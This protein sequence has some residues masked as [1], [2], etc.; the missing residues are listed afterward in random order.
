MSTQLTPNFSLEEL[1]LSSTAQRL[2]IDNTP[3]PDIVAALTVAANGMEQVRALLGNLPIH[4]DSGYRCQALN[5]AV[6]GA[7]DSAHMEGYAVDFICPAFGAPL[8]IA[9][10]VSAAG[11]AFDQLI[12]EGTWVHISFDPRLRGLLLSAHFGPGGT[13]YSNGIAS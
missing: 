5:K 1:T 9:H 11:L 4:V 13:S 7:A 8:A 6:G 12:M 2:G 10:A 3:T